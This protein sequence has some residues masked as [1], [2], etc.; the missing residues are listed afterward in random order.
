MFLQ[1]KNRREGNSFYEESLDYSVCRVTGHTEIVWDADKAEEEITEW[2]KLKY[3]DIAGMDRG[4]LEQYL[5]QLQLPDEMIRLGLTDIS[6]EEFGSAEIVIRVR[7]EQEGSE[8]YRYFCVTGDKTLSVFDRK[9]GRLGLRQSLDKK[10]FC[11]AQLRKLADGI[12]LKDYD[13]VISLIEGG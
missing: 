2:P 5:E 13:G 10:H 3:A 4:E 9:D 1:K 6:L 12:Y 7:R 8:R 11:A